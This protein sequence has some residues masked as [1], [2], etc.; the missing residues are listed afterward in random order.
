MT[1]LLL[2]LQAG[3]FPLLLE[4]QWMKVNINTVAV[5]NQQGYTDP[6]DIQTIAQ[7]QIL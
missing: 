2:P 7:A 1:C 5:T 6:F 3:H 4:M